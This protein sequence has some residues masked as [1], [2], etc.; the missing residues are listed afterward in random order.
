MLLSTLLLSFTALVTAL[1]GH[2]H[3]TKH[4]SPK[5]N[6]TSGVPLDSV[7]IF[8]PPANYTIPR[9]L[10][11]RT[12]QLQDCG[13]LLATWEN[14]GPNN[15]TFPYFPIY[16]STD[17]GLTWSERTKVY[18]Q[19][20]GWGLR[21]QPFLYQL[22]HDV[23]EYKAGTV[24]LAGSSIPD[25]LSQTQLELYASTDDAHTFNFVAHVARGGVALPNNGETPVWEPFL[26]EYEGDLIYYYSDQ[27]DPEAGQKLVHQVTSD[28]VTYGPVV[29]DVKYGTYDWRP[30]MTTVSLLSNGSYLLTYEFYGAVE[31]A[32]AVYYRLSS[33]PTKFDEA[34]YGALITTAEGKYPVGSPYNVWTPAGGRDGTIVVT[35]GT[36]EGVWVS[37][38]LTESWT[39]EMTMEK[40]SYTRSLLVEQDQKTILIVGGGIL[41]GTDNNVTASTI[42]VTNC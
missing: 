2:P 28:L 7:L 11:A 15:N 23:G 17:G 24:L 25:D 34:G 14:Y 38:D 13:T 30:G 42:D 21:Y 39:Y 37:R 18:D 36:D 8:D 16:Q 41:G 22:E 33:D 6:A 12:L 1:P 26:M 5:V 27:R 19:V 31:E 29:D 10:Y 4:H 40:T 20:N 3:P 35:C 32:F 9:T